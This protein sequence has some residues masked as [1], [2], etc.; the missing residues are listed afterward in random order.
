[1]FHHFGTAGREQVSIMIE[2]LTLESYI[3]MESST[4]FESDFM[5][6][7]IIG[8]LKPWKSW[9]LDPKKKYYLERRENILGNNNFLSSSVVMNNR[10]K[11]NHE[12]L[13]RAFL[14]KYESELINIKFP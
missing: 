5:L 3:K 12:A 14:S 4:A 10:F 9:V 7:K 11:V 2:I 8:T 13:Y 1:L 6:Y